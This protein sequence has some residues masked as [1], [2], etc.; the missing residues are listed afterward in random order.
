MHSKSRWWYIWFS[1]FSQNGHFRS[2]LNTHQL[3][4]KEVLNGFFSNLQHQCKISVRFRFH[5]CWR[6]LDFFISP[7]SEKPLFSGG[8][9]GFPKMLIRGNFFDDFDWFGSLNDK[10]DHHLYFVPLVG[11]IFLKTKKT[12]FLWRPF[13]RFNCD[14]LLIGRAVF[15]LYLSSVIW[16]LSGKTN[17]QAQVNLEMYYTGKVRYSK[18]QNWF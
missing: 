2:F 5:G 1:I 10:N 8:H 13:W 7:G 17:L 6:R 12:N 9:L 18:L 15:A 16:E 4:L 14:V 11:F 3:L